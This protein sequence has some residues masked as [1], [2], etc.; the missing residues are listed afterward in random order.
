MTEI[1]MH[2]AGIAENAGV[3]GEGRELQDAIQTRGE[4][5]HG[6]GAEG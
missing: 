1:D 2:H 4:A 3:T 5:P 6:A